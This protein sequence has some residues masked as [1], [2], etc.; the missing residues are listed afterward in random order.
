MQARDVRRHCIDSFMIF[1]IT[2]DETIANTYFSAPI[3]CSRQLNT[4]NEERFKNNL[5]MKSPKN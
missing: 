2:L 4:R 5:R 1:R 3:Y